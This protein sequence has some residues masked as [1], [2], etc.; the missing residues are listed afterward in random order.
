MLVSGVVHVAAFTRRVETATS[1]ASF[2]DDLGAHHDE[3][4]HVWRLRPA[5]AGTAPAAVRHG[6]LARRL[7]CPIPIVPTE[8]IG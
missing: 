3:A 1:P 2:V 4:A 7:L 5:K 8:S 6:P